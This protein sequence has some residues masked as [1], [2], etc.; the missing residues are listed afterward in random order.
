MTRKQHIWTEAEVSELIAINAAG[1]TAREAAARLGITVQ[2]VFTKSHALRISWMNGYRNKA[3][4]RFWT[5]AEVS[6]LIAINAAGGT[7]RE[8]AARLGFTTQQVHAKSAPLGI[9]WRK[10]LPRPTIV[11]IV[12]YRRPRARPAPASRVCLRC[13][14]SF[15]PA[16]RTNY[17]C[18][19]CTILNKRVLEEDDYHVVS[20]R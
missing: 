5:E 15:T 13:L 17:L 11:D 20:A 12:A 2:Q 4:N 16:W 3:Q 1:G 9:V 19:P 18:R 7:P 6:E 10:G 14:E 8:A